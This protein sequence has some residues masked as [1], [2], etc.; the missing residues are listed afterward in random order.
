MK[1]IEY[2]LAVLVLS[3]FT[4]SI[5][6]ISIFFFSYQD[7]F[8]PGIYVDG[9]E[10]A[11]LTKK[12]A[13]PK[14]QS[15]KQTPNLSLEIV[16]EEIKA[17]SQNHELQ[18][19]IN[20]QTVLSEAYEVNRVGF[21]LKRLFNALLLLKTPKHFYSQLSY[22]Q[23]DLEKIVQ[24]LKEKVDLE[25]V[26]PSIELVYSNNPNSLKLNPGAYGKNLELAQTVDRILET[27]KKK[28][29]QD[30][31]NQLSDDQEYLI[32][33][34]AFVA[35][36]SAVL[37]EEESQ[38]A[39]ARAKKFVGK[40]IIAQTHDVKIFLEDKDLVRLLSFPAGL[41]DNKIGS[42]LQEWETKVTRE[43]SNAVFSYNP[44]TLEV[45]EFKAHK[46]GLTLDQTKTKQE[47]VNVMAAIEN[48][49]NDE[50]NNQ[51]D[52]E[53]KLAVKVKEP[54]VTL[55]DTNNLGINELIGF[56]DSFYAHSIPSRIHNVRITTEKIS[57]HIVPPG[58]EF[59]FNK[60]LGEVSSKT[61]YKPAYVIQGGRTVLGDGGGV[62]Q[63]STT[64]FRA[65]LDAGLEVSK[66]KAHS[67]RV[68]YYELDNKPG[69]DAT[70]YAGDIDLRFINDTGKHLLITG[71]TDSNNLYMTI[72]IYGTS[73]GR[74]TEISNY[75]MWGY[76]SPPP[77][78]YIPDP[79]LPPG[80]IKQVDW[81]ASGIKSEF[82]NVIRDKDGNIIREDTY[83]SSYQPW[84]AKYLRGE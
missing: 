73:D 11:G 21:P 19:I 12:E 78:V 52:F 71:T 81:A 70:V 80:V 62:C 57:N 65:I 25:G 33:V 43:P 64:T 38:L 17:I 29:T 63:V 36:T 3:V 15:S 68:S 67:Y 18:P 58:T 54:E 84:S 5:I 4:A 60:T 41:S 47:L 26:E 69:F 40:R 2:L 83:Y 61:G 24:S 35:S 1:K 23:S 42:L 59:S 9:I 74:S 44:Q 77:P 53:L 50:N 27:V 79:S 32:S 39:L 34:D 72:S 37:N 51:E 8:Y 46:N 45:Y 76:R 16:T 48:A 28:E 20:Y 14:L 55:A 22:K 6:A 82:T 31:I 56:G 13:L 7:K 10:L 30:A 49:A 75:K 66:R